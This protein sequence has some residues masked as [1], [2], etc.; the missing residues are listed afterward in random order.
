M[1]NFV[2]DIVIEPLRHDLAENLHFEIRDKMLHWL[3]ENNI[4]YENLKVNIYSTRISI[5]A[6]LNTTAEFLNANIHDIIDTIKDGDLVTSE[7][8]DISYY[9]PIINILAFLDDECLEFETLGVKSSSENLINFNKYIQID[10]Y[11]DYLQKMSK[12]F[13]NSTDDCVDAISS[14]LK[15]RSTAIGKKLSI[16]RERIGNL[17]FIDSKLSVVD[18]QFDDSYLELPTPIIE[19]VIHNHPN[20]FSTYYDDGNISNSFLIVY[21]DE[22]EKAN[23][24]RSNINMINNELKLIKK[25]FKKDLESE[26]SEYL[27]K[28]QWISAIDSLG[29]MYDKNLRVEK[30]AEKIADELLIADDMYSNLIKASQLMKADLGTRT[31]NCYPGLKGVIGSEMLKIEGEKTGVA[32]AIREQYLPD[33]NGEM[34]ETVC[35]GILAIADRIHDL[36]GLEILST[37]NYKHPWT[38][39]SFDDILKIMI[40]MEPE[41]NLGSIIENT[42]YSYT[43]NSIGVFD[44]DTVFEKLYKFFKTR[45][46][47]MLYTSGVED[48]LIDDVFI[49]KDVAINN[50]YRKLKD[51][52]EIDDEMVGFIRRLIEYKKL[53][54]SREAVD[55]GATSIEAE[56]GDVLK[57]AKSKSTDVI[58][59]IEILYE[60]REDFYNLI[61]SYN[62]NEVTEASKSLANNFKE[63]WL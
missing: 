51:L 53:I 29:S 61:E 40:D 43:E 6:A 7:F 41:I 20:I 63:M 55:G 60:Y 37:L 10:S 49:G 15:K 31:V 62:E 52:S 11:D 27:P 39:R 59:F 5:L 14:A 19:T 38:L 58:S 26:L 16:S 42:L 13:Y 28:L 8:G 21:R 47:R 57:Y 24:K 45:F 17:C 56:I 34:P 50:L 1:G 54:N 44:Y 33:F 23:L 32:D 22:I 46:K 35:G 12:Y 4:E 30:I 25:L 2:L 18:A 48:Y 3:S 9:R 36:A